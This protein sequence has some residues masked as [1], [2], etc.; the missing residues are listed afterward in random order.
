MRHLKE[1]VNPTSFTDRGVLDISNSAVR[2]NINTLLAGSTKSCKLT[3]YIALEKARKVL[4]YFHIHLPATPFMEGDHGVQVFN[5]N[6][7]GHLYGMKD[8]GEVVTKDENTNP[9]YVY[10]EYRQN[11]R[12]MFDIFCEIVTEEEMHSLTDAGGKS[13]SDDEPTDDREERLEESKGLTTLNKLS[14]RQ[15]EKLLNIME[16][17]LDD[18]QVEL[19]GKKVR[20]TDPEVKKLEKSKDYGKMNKVYSKLQMKT[21][22]IKEDSESVTLAGPETG[23]R[24]IPGSPEVCT[25]AK[26]LAA[27]ILS[28][29]KFNE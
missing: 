5:I 24:R 20:I 9:Y 10:F 19:T 22:G 29:K 6:Q 17:K 14:Q 7:F 13:M 16:K 23:P 4:A 28:K 11:D 25:A 1:E 18:K 26:M 15:K 21:L 8:N 2:D 12:G 3:P 27:K